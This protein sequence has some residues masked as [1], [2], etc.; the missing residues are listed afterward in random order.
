[1]ASSSQQQTKMHAQGTNISTG[2]AINP[3]HGQVAFGI[4]LEQL[5]LVDGSHTQ[6]ALDGRNE[7]RSLEE[8]TSQCLD[9]LCDFLNTQASSCA[10]AISH[11][12]NHI[13]TD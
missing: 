3:K 10:Q 8:G 1:V 5:A 6:S 13:S 9:G 4:E 2:F 11:C 12:T 7:W